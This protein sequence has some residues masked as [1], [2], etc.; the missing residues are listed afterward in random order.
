MK[1]K[2]SRYNAR[3]NII[4]II[5]IIVLLAVLHLISIIMMFVTGKDTE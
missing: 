3:C 4:K 5:L 1:T 2:Q